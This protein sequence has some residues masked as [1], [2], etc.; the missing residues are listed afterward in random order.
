ML[1]CKYV[2]T[3]VIS[4][5]NKIHSKAWISRMASKKGL[6]VCEMRCRCDKLIK[7][8]CDKFHP[9]SDLIYIKLRKE[10][11]EHTQ[12]EIK[13]AIS[14]VYKM[15]IKNLEMI[16]IILKLEKK[17][18]DMELQ[19]EW[20]DFRTTIDDIKKISNKLNKLCKLKEELV[21]AK[22]KQSL[23]QM[24]I[25]QMRNKILKT[26]LIIMDDKLDQFLIM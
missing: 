25:V 6:N 20:I 16:N 26:D 1:T 11:G 17:I 13:I 21:R 4:K 14:N 9:R 15:D 3:C 8:N 7:G 23:I 10:K 12:E 22:N 19:I 24:E 18:T 2:D 5:C